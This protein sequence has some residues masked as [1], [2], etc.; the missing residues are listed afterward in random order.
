MRDKCSS[1]ERKNLS[2][3]A[4]DLRNDDSSYDP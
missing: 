4:G 1:N 2:L 3:F